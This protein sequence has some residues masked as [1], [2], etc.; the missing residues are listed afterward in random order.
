MYES[1][2]ICDSVG[3][4]RQFN[5][6]AYK[7]RAGEDGA[8]SRVDKDACHDWS[9]GSRLFKFF[10]KDLCSKSYKRNKLQVVSPNHVG[11]SHFLFYQ[12]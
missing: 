4:I 2:C 3:F 5:V 11:H 1:V 12:R 8:G 6:K 9:W 7:E 10:F